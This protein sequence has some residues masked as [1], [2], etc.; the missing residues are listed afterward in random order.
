[1]LVHCYGYYGL[2]YEIA[3]NNTYW[4]ALE[5]GW[6]LA[7]AHVRGGGEKGIRWHKQAT[8]GLRSR[9]WTDL[10]DCVAYLI[11]KGYTHPNVM[12]LSSHSA[13]SI[14]IW[15]IINRNPHLFKAVVMNYPFL[16]VLGLLLDSSQP[17][18]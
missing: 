4:A 9:N 5:N 13:G 17:L 14:T 2:S 6:S 11:Q 1:M 16:D 8:K 7:Y 15:N 3:F 18:T 12:V 10:E